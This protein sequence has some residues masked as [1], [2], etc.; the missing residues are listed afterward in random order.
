MNSI[1]NFIKSRNSVARLTTPAP[2][3]E[4]LINIFECAM[5]APDH[6]LLKPWK[7]LVIEGDA[8]DKLGQLMVQATELAGN[9]LNDEQR[10]KL[11]M[12]P[13]RAPMILVAICDYKA[14]DKVPQL[15]QFASLAAGVQN[16]LLAIE[17]LGFGA[18]WRTGKI[19]FN[20]HLHDLMNLEKHQQILGF[21]YLGTPEFQVKPKTRPSVDEFVSNWF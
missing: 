9:E 1:I 4:Q 8:R 21:I 15:E 19:T 11:A 6:K 20:R 13:L 17:S 3:S 7:Y 12:K 5:T 10:A 16:M 14:H 2:N 18:Y